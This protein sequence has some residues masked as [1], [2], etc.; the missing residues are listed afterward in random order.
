M[1]NE[2]NLSKEELLDH[3]KYAM[4]QVIC[5]GLDGIDRLAMESSIDYFIKTSVSRYT[6][7]EIIEKFYTSAESIRLFTE[8]LKETGADED[9]SDQILQ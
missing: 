2:I 6:S 9:S 4:T 3:L 1:G 8:F 7:E 5:E